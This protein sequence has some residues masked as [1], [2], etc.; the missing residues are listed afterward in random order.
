MLRPTESKILFLQQLG[1]GLRRAEGKERLVVLDFIGNHHS[2]LHKPQALG[3][4]GSGYKQL[5]EF[6]RKVETRRLELPTGC[7]INFD[8]ELIDF[9]KSLDG[10]GVARD[11]EAL[12]DGLGR[13]PTLAEFYRSGANLGR[14]RK[15]YESWFGLVKT[16][17]DLGETES[18]ILD[19]HQDLL[20]ELEITTMTK[21]FK[22]VLLEAFQEL[23]GWHIAPTLGQLAER[24]WQILQRRRPLLA[25][26][27]DTLE[28]TQ[29]GTSA[30]WQRYWRSNP[31][32]AWI[33]GN[34]AAEQNSLFRVRNDFFEPVF[35]VAPEQQETLTEMVQEL[36]DYRLAAYEARRTTT[37]RTDNVIPFRRERPD[38][39][40]LP[41]FPNLRIACGHF[42]TARAD[43]EEHR[44]LGSGYGHLDPA[45]HFIARASGNSMNG[46]KNPIRDG[47]YLLLE[48]VSP[49]NA[50]SITGT[51]MAIERQDRTGED[52]YLLRGVTKQRDG[53]YV[54]VANNRDY[55]DLHVTPEMAE[56]LRTLA[57][58]KAVIDPL[59]LAVGESFMREEIP[60]LFGAEF[61]PGNWNSGHVVLPERNA[62]VLL[63]T[64]NKQG[65]SVDHRY[66]DRWIDDHTFQWSS[67]NSATPENK[68]GREIIEHEK[69]G[70]TLHLFVR[71]TKLS[72]GK[73]APFTY[74]GKVRYKTHEGSAPMSVLLEV[75]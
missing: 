14:M 13:R 37:T 74:H 17:D 12:R 58:L 64:L 16:M 18:A 28:D 65:K 62:H 41:Y 43:V 50:G 34:Q 52:Q 56:E 35:N 68:R 69:L 59:E 40:E 20:R 45:R 71:E 29:N 60:P 72:G 30:G 4:I 49:T 39:I 3:Q 23:D 44:R 2:F 61:N 19:A 7:Y 31:V 8:L 6:A 10:D 51:I 11:Y 75:G 15:E 32:N 21:S 25:D 9:L 38:A 24:S 53:S 73:A 1:R 33:G 54:L 55:E 70:I 36:I 57:R 66:L 22:M 5:A 67:Q 27:P 48:L 63:V 26:L 42:R 46:G 47:D